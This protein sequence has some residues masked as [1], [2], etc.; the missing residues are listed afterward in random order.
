MNEPPAAQFDYTAL[1]G[2]PEVAL[3]LEM[4]R[5]RMIAR[6][7]PVDLGDHIA[8]LAAMGATALKVAP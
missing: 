4:L 7:A 2:I 5:E 6:L 3:R 8:R 1:I